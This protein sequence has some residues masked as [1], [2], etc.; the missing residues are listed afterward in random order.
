MHI[1]TQNLIIRSF[2][3]N[4][5]DDVFEY[6]SNPDATYYL[7]E[8]VMSRESVTLLISETDKHFAIVNKDYEKVV[9]HLAFYAWSGE[10]TYEIGWVINPLYQRK[11]IALEAAYQTLKFGFETLGVH[12]VVAAAQPEN[13]ASYGLMEK[14]GMVREGHFRQCIPKGDGA[15]W[16]EYFYSMLHSDFKRN[17]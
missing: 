6:M 4:D 5:V 1:E 12:R 9:G 10:H 11:G 17:G 2:L 7:P 16:D 14:L 8:G 15:W 3:P 13:L